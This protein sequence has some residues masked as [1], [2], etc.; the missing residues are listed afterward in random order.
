MSV[1]PYAI[2][3]RFHVRAACGTAQG[4]LAAETKDELLEM[5]SVLRAAVANMEDRDDGR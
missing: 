1:D 2:V 5:L 3:R 4:E